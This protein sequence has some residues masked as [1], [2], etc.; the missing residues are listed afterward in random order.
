MEVK[1]K[2]A[3]LLY[4]ESNAK[5]AAFFL[6]GSVE[7]PISPPKF[8]MIRLQLRGKVLFHA[9]GLLQVERVG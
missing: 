1:D 3:A 4:R 6:N 7:T 9:L 2:L 5:Q 8:S